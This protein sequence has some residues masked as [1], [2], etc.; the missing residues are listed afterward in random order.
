MP[1]YRQ[2]LKALSRAVDPEQHPR[3]SYST[4]KASRLTNK[5][6]R[7]PI[8]WWFNQFKKY[9]LLDVESE[10]H[11][12]SAAY[13]GDECAR[14]RLIMSNLRLVYSIAKEFVSPQLCLSDLL[15]EG[16]IGLIQAAAKFEPEKGFR[17]STYATWWIRRN[18]GRALD[19]QSRFVRLPVYVS[20]RL[21]SIRKIGG[22]L[23]QQNGVVPDIEE[24]SIATGYKKPFLV[25][26][27]QVASC[28]LSLDCLDDRTQYKSRSAYGFSPASHEAVIE[29]MATAER[30]TRALAVLS[31]RQKQVFELRY[32]ILDGNPLTLEEVGQLLTLSRE[33]IR[34][35]ESAALKKLRGI[36]PDVEDYLCRDH[37]KTCQG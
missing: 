2:P 35:I 34:Q 17:F 8:A 6:W 14:E 9:P 12:A 28:P 13:A 10:R 36:Y 24:L 27:E 22:S 30:L 15:Q 33:R 29:E 23:Y 4:S 3:N 37:R 32:G 21:T 11:T 1:N 19:N 26:L 5:S 7:E 31:E 25:L 18:I 20:E 16:H